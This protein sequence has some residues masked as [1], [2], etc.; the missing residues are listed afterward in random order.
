MMASIT[1]IT[2]NAISNGKIERYAASS[3]CWSLVA[4]ISAAFVVLAVFGEVLELIPKIIDVGFK[5]NW[6]LVTDRKAKARLWRFR[7]WKRRHCIDLIAFICWMIVMLG[8]VGELA[9]GRKSKHFDSLIISDL[10]D[11][12]TKSEKEV[13]VLNTRA[14]SIEASNLAASIELEKLRQTNNMVALAQKPRWQRFNANAFNKT[15]AGGVK[16]N[17]EIL[18]SGEATFFL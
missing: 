1:I 11:R 10:Q 3:D 7:F 6:H 13:G 16:T 4:D 18:Y 12:A 8:L 15:L 2:Q 17:V 5:K 14:A 9:A